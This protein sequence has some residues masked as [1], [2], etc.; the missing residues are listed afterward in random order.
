MRRRHRRAVKQRD[1]IGRRIG[2]IRDGAENLY[3]RSG[4]IDP[5]AVVGEAGITAGS[6]GRA[7]IEAVTAAAEIV[8]RTGAAVT[9]RHDDHDILRDQVVGGSAEATAVRRTER[10]VDGCDIPAGRF[11]VTHVIHRLGD[12]VHDNDTG[13][14]VEGIVEHITDAAGHDFHAVA[15]AVVGTVTKTTGDTGDRVT[16]VGDGSYCAG[17]VS[18]MTVAITRIVVGTTAVIVNT[19]VG[20]P[21]GALDKVPADDIIDITVTVV[22]DTVT[23]G[24]TAVDPDVTIGAGIVGARRVAA[25]EVTV[26]IHDTD[27]EHADQHTGV[28][29]LGVPGH[30][31]L[32]AVGIPVVPLVVR[33]FGR[34]VIVVRIVGGRINGVNA[35]AFDPFYHGMGLIRC[36][37]LIEVFAVQ[38]N[39][40]IAGER[41][42]GCRSSLLHGVG[43]GEL[44]PN[45]GD[46]DIV[47]NLAEAVQAR[48]RQGS[49]HILGV[50]DSY[51]VIEHDDE[52]VGNPADKARPIEIGVLIDI[53]HLLGVADR[54]QNHE[55]YQGGN[56]SPFHVSSTCPVKCCVFQVRKVSS[57]MTE[58]GHLVTVVDSR[59][60]SCTV[61]V[62]LLTTGQS[63]PLARCPR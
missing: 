29:G 10:A 6:V 11:Q 4:D 15:A 44:R 27:V 20:V 14:A 47:G 18:A 35:D 16:V 48:Q 28:A 7:D 57:A 5:T 26:V 46:A 30:V 3:A 41:A 49:A 2:R 56:N 24:F 37:S 32:D 17:N 54:H 59:I 63:P 51:V 33:E 9:G 58:L 62:G 39:F 34:R 1:V 53:A 52:S 23:R 55:K 21:V 40:V 12:I 25:A 60:T 19:L 43:A 31:G 42:V 13:G 50:V 38:V 45:G 36:D 8:S 61:N 22:I